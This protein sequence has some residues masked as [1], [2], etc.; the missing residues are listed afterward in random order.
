MLRALIQYNLLITLFLVI[1]IVILF[2][3]FIRER[4]KKRVHSRISD[5]KSFVE[6]IKYS[7]DTLKIDKKKYLTAFKNAQKE[8]KLYSEF[9]LNVVEL[10]ILLIDDEN[11]IIYQNEWFD[12]NKINIS[13]LLK[14]ELKTFEISF[15]NKTILVTKQKQENYLVFTLNDITELKEL[16]QQIIAKEKLAYLGEMSASIAHEFKNSLAV[17]KGFARIIQKRSEMADIV[18]KTAVD[19]DDEINYFY[20]ILVDYLSYSREINL[21]ISQFSVMDLVNDIKGKL[22]YDKKELIQL[23]AESIDLILNGDRDKIKQVLINLIK[24]GLEASDD[25]EIL[26]NLTSNNNKKI[27]EIIDQG[28]GI[29]DENKE[30]IFNPFFTTKEHGTGLGL[31]ITYNII[32]AHNGTIKILDNT[33]NGTIF[34]IVFESISDI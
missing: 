30:K 27:V 11:T 24:N 16:E 34:K 29:S 21:N 3:L 14:S 5:L 26:V 20:G 9:I 7:L 15:E 12:E 2:F 1:I 22:F 28:I 31:A 6:P 8:T 32:V 25:K 23:K 13:N 33:P 19:I 17:I 18:K 4:R 10:G